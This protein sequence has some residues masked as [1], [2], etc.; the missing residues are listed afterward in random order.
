MISLWPFVY[1]THCNV[2]SLVSEFGMCKF[3]ENGLIGERKFRAWLDKLKL[4]YLWIAQSPETFAAAFHGKAKRPD[5]MVSRGGGRIAAIEVKHK[6]PGF[7]AG[8]DKACFGVDKEPDI[9]RLGE[10]EQRLGIPV[11]FAFFD[12]SAMEDGAGCDGCLAATGGAF[13][14]EA[15]CS[16]FP[17]FLSAAAGADEAVRPASFEEK[18]SAGRVVGKPLVEGGSRHWAV[19]FPAARHENEFRTSGAGVKDL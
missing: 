3:E 12:G 10:F 19:V 5:A 8:R 18:S 4:D 15:L 7:W 9:K 2:V 14:S 1:S 11:W 6:R 17:S 13:V 16:E